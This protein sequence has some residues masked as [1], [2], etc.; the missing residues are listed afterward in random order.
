MP[1]LGIDRF[2]IMA[3]PDIEIRKVSILGDGP[4][5]ASPWSG[6]HIP[7]IPAGS[8]Q[9]VISMLAKGQEETHVHCDLIYDVPQGGPIGVPVHFDIDIALSHPGFW[10]G[11]IVF[12][13]YAT[14]APGAPGPAE[15]FGVME[16]VDQHNPHVW[17]HLDKGVHIISP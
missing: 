16:L 8:V 6:T 17:V 10:I 2:N 14:P 4:H 1:P 13:V 15:A 12:G 11:H 3:D 7:H 9:D 5:G